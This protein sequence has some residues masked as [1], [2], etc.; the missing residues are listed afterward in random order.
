M[1]FFSN[2]QS[3]CKIPQLLQSDEYSAQNLGAIQMVGKQYL[4]KISDGKNTL[5]RFSFTVKE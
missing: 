3:V 2:F 4:C 5:S 1:P